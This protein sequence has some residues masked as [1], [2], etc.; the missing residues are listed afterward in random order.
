MSFSCLH[1]PPD[2][3]PP[4]EPPPHCAWH[5][6]FPVDSTHFATAVNSATWTQA[7]GMGDDVRQVAQSALAPQASASLQQASLRHASH[8][9]LL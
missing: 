3:D 4:L 2:E 9:S 5:A 8:A 7:G 1:T 6:G